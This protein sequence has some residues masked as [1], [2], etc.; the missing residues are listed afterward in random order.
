MS[1]LVEILKEL[2]TIWEKMFHLCFQVEGIMFR[3]IIGNETKVC[4]LDSQ[5][6]NIIFTHQEFLLIELARE[7]ATIRRYGSLSDVPQK[8]T[9]RGVMSNMRFTTAW[10]VILSLN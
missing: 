6:R 3:K 10:N 5:A 2:D 1:N 7:I 9:G 8:V 4:E